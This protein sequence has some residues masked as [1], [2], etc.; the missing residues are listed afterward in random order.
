MLI[1][2][3]KADRKETNKEAIRGHKK[4]LTKIMNRLNNLETLARGIV[5]NQR[6]QN[7][8]L[9]RLAGQFHIYLCYVHHLDITPEDR[10]RT[11]TNIRRTC[12]VEK[13]KKKVANKEGDD[14]QPIILD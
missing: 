1:G 9:E 10:R 7:E 12:M 4:E 6:S 11:P 5:A 3:L 8:K 14:S 13:K 2:K